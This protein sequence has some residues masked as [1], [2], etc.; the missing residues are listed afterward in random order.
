VQLLRAGP[1]DLDVGECQLRHD[2]LEEGGPAEQGLDERD[3]Q[4]GTGEGEHHA[5]QSRSRTDVAHRL[6]LTDRAAQQR[7]VQQVPLPQPRRLA[8]ADQAA[9]HTGV[10]QQRGEPLRERQGMRKHPRRHVRRRGC[11]T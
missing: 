6:V 4:V 3:A 1:D 2:L 10:G 11:F 7:A 9:N 8:G 5:R